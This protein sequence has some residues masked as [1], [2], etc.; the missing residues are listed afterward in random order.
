[1]GEVLRARQE[2]GLTPKY[3]RK[4]CGMVGPGHENQVALAEGSEETRLV[5]YLGN[6]IVSTFVEPL[7]RFSVKPVLNESPANLGDNSVFI[8]REKGG[9]DYKVLFQ[10]PEDSGK[11]FQ[12]FAYPMP[13]GRGDYSWEV[14]LSCLDEQ[15][16]ELKVDTTNRDLFVHALYVSMLGNQRWRG[17]GDVFK[18]KTSGEYR[19]KVAS[20]LRLDKPSQVSVKEHRSN[21]VISS[22]GY[23][24]ERW[25]KR[26]AQNMMKLL[27]TLAGGQK[28]DD[29]HVSETLKKLED[30]LAEIREDNIS[31]AQW[32]DTISTFD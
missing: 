6:C 9:E 8:P 7:G 4:T 18:K 19:F 29:E 30:R 3:C 12:V 15:L 24:V 20:R 25:G 14:S 27:V 1:M 16:E 28:L 22:N 26:S 10:H 21:F 23:R 11:S 2:N 13:S 31:I 5:D 17:Y 32:L